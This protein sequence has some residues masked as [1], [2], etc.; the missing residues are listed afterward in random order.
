MHDTGLCHFSHLNLVQKRYI[1]PISQ[2]VFSRAVWIAS[3]QFNYRNVI[4]LSVLHH[5]SLLLKFTA[6][7]VFFYFYINQSL[8]I[9]LL[10]KHL[11][12]IVIFLTWKHTDLFGSPNL[13]MFFLV[14][15]DD[16]LNQ[17]LNYSNGDK[18]SPINGPRGVLA[19]LIENRPSQRHSTTQA[20]LT[21]TNLPNICVFPFI[22][23]FLKKWGT[24]CIEPASLFSSHTYLRYDN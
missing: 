14:S 5:A 4:P 17:S 9:K 22:S 16:I 1:N 11:Q 13:I 24:F 18:S 2:L 23:Q 19:L 10:I 12:I 15:L 8:L 20:K 3:V 21:P 6:H 7:L